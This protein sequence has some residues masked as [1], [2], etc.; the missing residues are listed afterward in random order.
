VQNVDYALV[1]GSTR[2]LS[3]RFNGDRTS[4]TWRAVINN[5]WTPDDTDASLLAVATITTSYDGIEDKTLVT[6]TYDGDDVTFGP[7]ENLLDP[8]PKVARAAVAGVNYYV[9]EVR[10]IPPSGLPYVFFTGRVEVYPKGD[11]M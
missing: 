11:I 4:S 8:S 2:I 9:H 10:E 1:Q 6:C 5:V 7:T 3:F